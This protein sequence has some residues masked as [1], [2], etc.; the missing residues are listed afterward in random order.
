[1][2]SLAGIAATE[3]GDTRQ[4]TT[5]CH[6]GALEERSSD[7]TQC[8]TPF[9][10]CRELLRKTAF[11]QHPDICE[12]RLVDHLRGNYL[13]RSL[14]L[15]DRAIES[16]PIVNTRFGAQVGRSH[17][18]FLSQNLEDRSGLTREKL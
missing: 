10:L 6:S 9:Y 3:A 1:M 18:P 2:I 16:G 13:H 11:T 7:L 5:I 15:V 17:L 4:F 12:D 14:Q 8:I